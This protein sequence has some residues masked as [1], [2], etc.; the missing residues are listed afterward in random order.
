MRRAFFGQGPFEQTGS[1]SYPNGRVLGTVR[2]A[3]E[4]PVTQEPK[5]ILPGGDGKRG[6]KVSID[7][8]EAEDLLAAL[9][10][11]LAPLTSEEAEKAIESEE[12][13][14]ELSAGPFPIVVRLRDKLA[15]FVETAT[16]MD[17]IEI[18][19]GE[20]TVTQKAVDCAKSIG[21][22]GVVETVA[23]AGGGVGLL[24]LLLL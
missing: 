7:K 15:A 14:R 20:I 19:H 17:T 12:C 6:G 13:L 24:A 16:P 23:I 21:R 18:S 9:D 5:P 22:L 3:Q 4:P 10:E 2:L 1:I 8:Q 11:V